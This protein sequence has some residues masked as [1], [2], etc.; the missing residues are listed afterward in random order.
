[1]LNNVFSAIAISVTLLI[2]SLSWANDVRHKGLICE[3]E[4]KNRPLYGSGHTSHYAFWFNADGE[5]NWFKVDN[6]DRNQNGNKAEFVEIHRND[7]WEFFTKPTEIRFFVR[8]DKNRIVSEHYAYVD[9]YTLKLTYHSFGAI[10][11]YQCEAIS[12]KNAFEKRMQ[13][14]T[15]S[16]QKLLKK[17]KI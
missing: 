11:R 7:G 14:I 12:T 8:N 15:S 4:D 13:R 6:W 10:Y 9:R 16:I 5:F 2:P 17:R 1:M 3:T